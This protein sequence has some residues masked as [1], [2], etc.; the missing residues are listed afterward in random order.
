MRLLL[1]IT[2]L[3]SFVGS[4]AG[5]IDK[6][7]FYQSFASESLEKIDSF[8]VLLEKEEPS[9]TKNAYTG[10]LLMKKAK[11]LSSNRDKITYFVKGRKL[12]E[13]EIEL[14]PNNGELRYIRFVIQENSPAIMQYKENMSEDTEYI[15]KVF[16]SF[17]SVVKKS[18]KEYSKH[19]DLL[20]I[21]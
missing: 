16:H 19:S 17:D 11:F 2:A 10:A 18:V 13:K 4:F 12:L 5:G 7:Q 15:K 3:L 20:N 6:G 8:L 9:S 1:F 14:D 21:N